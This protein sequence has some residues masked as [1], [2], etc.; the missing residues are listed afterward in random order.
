MRGLAGAQALQ[1]NLPRRRDE[2]HQIEMGM[3]GSPQPSSDPLSA[4]S[5][6]GRNTSRISRRRSAISR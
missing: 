4:Q 2:D 1:A 6:R 5:A 3:I